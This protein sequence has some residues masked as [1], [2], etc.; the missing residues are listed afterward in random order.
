MKSFALLF[1]IF[2]SGANAATAY[3]AEIAGTAC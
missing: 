3:T 2:V 1:T